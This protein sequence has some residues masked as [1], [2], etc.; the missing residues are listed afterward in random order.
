MPYNTG[1]KG[2]F[3]PGDFDGGI[4]QDFGTEQIDIGEFSNDRYINR[5]NAWGGGLDIKYFFTKHWALGAEGFIVDA[6][7][8]SAGGGLATLTF[9]W[10]IGCSRFAPYLFTGFGASAG[11]SHTSRFFVE[12]HPANGTEP[13]FR[14]NHTIRNNHTN[15]TGQVGAGL[16]IRITKHIGLMGD[17]AYNVL[18]YG[19][20]DFGMARFGVTLSY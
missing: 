18:E 4:D 17:Y 2:D 9:R 19:N 10:P 12:E 13:E 7:D 3:R 1:H 14:Q 16:E 20:N 15:A 5:D 11:G 6:N 8:N